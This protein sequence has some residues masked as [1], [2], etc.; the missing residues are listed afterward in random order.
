MVLLVH[1][2]PG[3]AV[4]A[5]ATYVPAHSSTN[6]G[7]NTSSSK[8]D[9]IH[10]P[11]VFTLKQLGLWRT[12]FYG[13]V[14]HT[15]SGAS[16]SSKVK[17]KSRQQ[18]HK[19]SHAVL[20]Q[21]WWRCHAQSGGQ[22]ELRGS[23]NVF[24]AVVSSSTLPRTVRRVINSAL[25]RWYQH[26]DLDILKSMERITAIAPA[27]HSLSASRPLQTGADEIVY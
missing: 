24:P 25:R 12:L 17:S 22:I 8:N 6:I 27:C 10:H 1:V 4:Q 9:W 18:H 3:P 26:S 5:G 15:V 7:S 23:G 13:L 20:L 16:N 11:A 2:F 14:D 19:G 21:H